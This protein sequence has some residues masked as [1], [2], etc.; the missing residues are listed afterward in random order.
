[1]KTILTLLCIAL[2]GCLAWFAACGAVVLAYRLAVR[3]LA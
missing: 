3:M 1:M 2:L